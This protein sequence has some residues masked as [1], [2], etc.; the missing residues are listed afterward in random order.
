[1]TAQLKVV[2]LSGHMSVSVWTKAIEALKMVANKETDLIMLAIKL[3]PSNPSAP[4]PATLSI[5]QLAQTISPTEPRFTF[6]R[7]SPGLNDN[8]DTSLLL[9]SFTCP[10]P[11]SGIDIAATRNRML[12]PLMKRSVLEVARIEAD[13]SPDKSFEIQDPAEITE[14]LILGGLD[15]SA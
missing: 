6:C 15:L 8:N 3:V 2:R 11:P 9:F 7:I 5:P 4:D 1:M 13:L 10:S 12:Y 14:D